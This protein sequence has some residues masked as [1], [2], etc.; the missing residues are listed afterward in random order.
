MCTN[1]TGIASLPEATY[2]G[3]KYPR[4]NSWNGTASEYVR[5]SGLGWRQV[6]SAMLDLLKD[7][8]YMHFNSPRPAVEDPE[9]PTDDDSDDE[10]N[11]PTPP[12]IN[13]ESE[14]RD[15]D[16]PPVMEDDDSDNEPNDDTVPDEQL[17]AQSERDDYGPPHP[18]IIV[19]PV[20]TRQIEELRDGARRTH[21]QPQT[22]ATAVLH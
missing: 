19:L 6:E 5:Q 4:S 1:H 13:D 21:V 12:S 3:L 20:E 16:P 14:N 2:T 9:P 7:K 15:D 8:P 17:G 18:N 10:D 22:N 11:D